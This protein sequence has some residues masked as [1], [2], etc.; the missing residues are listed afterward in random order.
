MR[1]IILVTAAAAALAAPLLAQDNSDRVGFGTGAAYPVAG[2]ATLFWEHETRYHNA[3]EIS[4]TGSIAPHDFRHVTDDDLAWGVGAAWKPCLSGSR[5][6]YG[7]MCLGVSLGAS[8]KDFRAVLHAGWQH[9]R[10][11]RKG[12]QFYWQAGVGATLPAGGNLFHAGA[13][14]GVKMPVRDRMQRNLKQSHI[15]TYK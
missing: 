7:S 2:N 1:R 13:G 15:N 4:V 12:W 9:S 5:N 6:R 14:M 10:A 8:P 11:L 3:W